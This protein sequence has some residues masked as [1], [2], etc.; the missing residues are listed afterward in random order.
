MSF[1]A[2][3]PN[4]NELYTFGNATEVIWKRQWEEDI[5]GCVQYQCD[6]KIRDDSPSTN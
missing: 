4:V 6:T 3:P 1:I 5:T 2:K